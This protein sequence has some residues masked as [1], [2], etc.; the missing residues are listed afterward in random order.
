MEARNDVG[1]QDTN[2]N[3]PVHTPDT[4]RGE[5][6][7][8]D[9]GQEAG[10]RRTGETGAGRPAGTSDARDSTR[11]NPEDEDPVDPKSRKMPPA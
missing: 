6:I 1:H 4:R 3:E 9:D 5:E 7:S 11:I 2:H 10:R 8:R